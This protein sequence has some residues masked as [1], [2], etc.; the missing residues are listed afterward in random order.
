MPKLL[1]EDWTRARPSNAGTITEKCAYNARKN[2]QRVE[3]AHTKIA[4]KESI[5]TACTKS[6]RAI[7]RCGKKAMAGIIPVTTLAQRER[8]VK[9]TSAIGVP[10]DLVPARNFGYIHPNLPAPWD[11]RWRFTDNH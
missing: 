11:G 1:E 6:H 10:P 4:S 3:E 9:S 7:H 2:P 5:G 8:A